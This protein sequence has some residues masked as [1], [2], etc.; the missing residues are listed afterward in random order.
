MHR[1]QFTIVLNLSRNWSCYIILSYLINQFSNIF[2][3]DINFDGSVLIN[4]LLFYKLICLSTRLALATFIMFNL[5]FVN[6]GVSDELIFKSQHTP[7]CN[8]EF[9]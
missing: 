3:N 8:W 7:V 6:K 1:G 9:N 4:I 5:L 2:L